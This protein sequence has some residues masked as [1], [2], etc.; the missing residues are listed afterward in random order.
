MYLSHSDRWGGCICC[1]PHTQLWV[2]DISAAWILYHSSSS[3]S[4]HR[5]IE[6]FFTEVRNATHSLPQLPQLLK[7][8]DWDLAASFPQIQSLIPY[9]YFSSFAPPLHPTPFL[10]DLNVFE[11]LCFLLIKLGAFGILIQ[12]YWDQ[13]L[14]KACVICPI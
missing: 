10:L 5:G 1:L 8:G 6:F 3:I 9:F 13:R 4:V 11:C 2:M 12:I 7:Q 14:I